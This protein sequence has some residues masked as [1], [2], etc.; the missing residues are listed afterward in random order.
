MEIINKFKKTIQTGKWWEAGF[1]ENEK[2]IKNLPFSREECAESYNFLKETFDQNWFR[3]AYQIH[4]PLVFYFFLSGTYGASFLIKL[5][6]DLINISKIEGGKHLINHLK[7]DKEN[8][9]SLLEEVRIGAWLIKQNYK[10]R[11]IEK[12]ADYEIKLNSAPIFVEIKRF[13]ESK[14]D[15][16]LSH[17]LNSYFLN[18]LSYFLNELSVKGWDLQIEATK[19]FAR[20]VIFA[21]TLNQFESSIE[22]LKKK[23]QSSLA[24]FKK[25]FQLGKYEG[26]TFHFRYKAK[27]LENL[28][29]AEILFTF[30]ET[31]WNT[32]F[33]PPEIKIKGKIKEVLE[34]F[35]K[36]KRSADK[37]IVFINCLDTRLD[38]NTFDS[39]KIWLDL[40][41]KKKYSFLKGV[42]FYQSYF[43][44]NQLQYWKKI[45]L[46]SSLDNSLRN[47]FATIEKNL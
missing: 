20:D 4:H 1:L 45:F 13:S 17:F 28:S 8:F 19:N 42:V 14:I 38:E 11:K 35:Q 16:I 30:P 43:R 36:I 44:E 27:K 12:G 22:F 34:Q 18:E 9:Y 2:V 23:I 31:F 32:F 47:F 3:K 7:Q 10:I 33:P 21:S 40:E 25:N 29:S 24:R 15:K 5:G 41:I 37:L 39:I 6:L 26:E 46:P